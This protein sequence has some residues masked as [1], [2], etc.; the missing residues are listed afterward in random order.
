MHCPNK[1]GGGIPMPGFFGPFFYKV[2]VLKIAFFYSNFTVIVCFFSHFCHNHH[3]NYQNYHHNY[4]CNHH[5]VDKHDGDDHDDD[6]HRPGP[7]LQVLSVHFI[8][9]RSVILPL[10]EGSPRQQFLLVVMIIMTMV[11]SMLIVRESMMIVIMMMM[12]IRMTFKL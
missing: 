12:M 2:I 7:P 8:K 11:I 5:N 4:H 3:Q 10:L 9:R 6:K 1:G